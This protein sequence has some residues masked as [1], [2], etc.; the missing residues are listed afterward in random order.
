[1]SE[2]GATTIHVYILNPQ[3]P[4]SMYLGYKIT[5]LIVQRAQI[6]T[7]KIKESLLLYCSTIAIT[8]TLPTTIHF[9]NVGLV[10]YNWKWNHT[11]AEQRALL[12]VL[13]MSQ[14]KQNHVSKNIVSFER[15]AYKIGIQYFPTDLELKMCSIC[16]TWQVK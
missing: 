9:P 12:K 10:Q 14:S 8:T 16:S 2:K 5:T 6:S 7:K 4:T 15:E 1:M 3:K 11:Y 13:L